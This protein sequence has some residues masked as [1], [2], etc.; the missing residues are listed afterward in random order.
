MSIPFVHLHVHTDFSLLD[1]TTKCKDIAKTC[2]EMGMTACA[3]TDHGNMSAT[4][5]FIEVMEKE[6]LKPIIGCEFYVAPGNYLDKNSNA[7]HAQGYHLVCLAENYEGYINMCHLNEEA[8]LKGYYYKPR[9]DKDLLRKYHKGVIALSACLAGEVAAKFL[10]GAD[11]QAEQAIDEYREIFGPDNYF[12]ELQDHGLPEDKIVIPKIIDAAHRKGIPLVCTNDSHYLKREHAEAHEVFLCIGTQTT[13]LDENRFKFP[14]G[15]E[16]YFK[17]PEEM[18]AL[19][20]QCPEA[21]ENTVKIAERCHIHIPTVEGDGA[22]H[23]PE[24]PLP[25]GYDVSTPESAKKER[26]KYLRGLAIEGMKE[27]YNI[28]VDAPEHTPQEQLY[29]DRMNYELGIIDQ[30]GFT[31]YYLVVWDFLHFA[32]VDGV[33]LGPGRGS[34]AGSIVAYLIHITD[35]DPIKYDLLFER[36]LNPERCSPPDFDIDLC[37]R[38]RHRVI[39]YVHD[40]Y[41]EGN[42]VQIGTFGTLKAKAVVKDVARALGRSFSEGNMICKMIPADPKMTLQKAYDES[43]ELQALIK[44]EPWVA[45]VWK[46]A[47]VLEGLNRN[48]SMHAA[49]VIICDTRVSNVCPISKGANNEPTTQFPAVPDEALGLLKMDFLGL[50]NLTIIQDALDLIE[51]NTGKH[52]ESSSIPDDDPKAYELLNSGKTIGVFQLESTGLQDL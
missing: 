44:N 17:S 23:Y 21:L 42:V 5:E 48:M 15:P 49:G 32:R 3:V 35:I 45:E 52:Y 19:F 40:R 12:L 25:E 37:E 47:K 13:M 26:A 43:P 16:Y 31:S 36:F 38:R 50:R 46:F 10:I 1:G 4:M 41:G 18:A 29:I 8:W 51:K 30:M 33:P 39:E 2:K 28:D 7:S 22:N 27:R 6:G 14:G 20:P 34:G 9:V 11:E 24:Y